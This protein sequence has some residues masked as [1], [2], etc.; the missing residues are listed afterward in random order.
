MPSHCQTM[1]KLVKKQKLSFAK[2]AIIMW[3]LS[4]FTMTFGPCLFSMWHLCS[5]QMAMKMN[6]HKYMQPLTDS[7]IV[8]VVCS[9][10]SNATQCLHC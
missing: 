2:Y 10:L 4:V 5:K 7:V 6:E 9:M 8:S 3:G 1:L